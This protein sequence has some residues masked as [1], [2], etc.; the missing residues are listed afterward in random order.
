MATALLAS[1]GIQ[2]RSHDAVQEL[3]A[4]HFVKPAA[5]P[6]E[7]TRKLAALMDRRHTSD[8]K[9]FVEIGAADL[10]E[11]RP[12]AAQFLHGALRLLGKSLPEVEQ[13]PMMSA[14]REL[15]RLKP[16]EGHGTSS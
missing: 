7:T 9:T 16:G 8:Y 2:A 12:W 10:E 1:K 4:L 13:S 5:L 14:I 6:T 11:F 15:E 3:L